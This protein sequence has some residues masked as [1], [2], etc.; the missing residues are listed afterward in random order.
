MLVWV[1]LLGTFALGLEL[2]LNGVL[3]GALS[4]VVGIPKISFILFWE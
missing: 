3:I 1:P 4:T 2:L